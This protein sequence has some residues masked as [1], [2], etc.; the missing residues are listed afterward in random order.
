[1]S[2]IRP[3]RPTDDWLDHAWRY[4]SPVL[5]SVVLLVFL[6][7]IP[8]GTLGLM[9]LEF[10]QRGAWISIT[11]ATLFRFQLA[12]EWVGLNAIGNWLLGLWVGWPSILIG[13][14]ALNA[15]KD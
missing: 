4:L 1:M 5:L 13:W 15:W 6:V 7:A 9:V 11:P 2:F 8:L 3:S 10:L 14:T 12:T